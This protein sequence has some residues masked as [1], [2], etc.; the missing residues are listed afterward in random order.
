MFND[1]LSVEECGNL[2]REMAECVFPFVCAHGRV[3]MVPVVEIGGDD[4]CGF[5]VGLSE[6]GLGMKEGEQE[7][8]GMEFVRAFRRWKGVGRVGNGR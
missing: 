8:E 6:G 5:G 4:G 3:G 1:V 2:V 7:D